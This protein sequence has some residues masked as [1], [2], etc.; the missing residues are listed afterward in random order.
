MISVIIPTC[1]RPPEFLKQAIDSVLSQSL[2]PSEIIVVDNGTRDAD[3]TAIPEG[4]TLYRL[5]PRVGPS[6]A[7]NFGAAMAKSSYLAFLDDDDWWD[8]NFI[9]EAWNILQ[10]EGVNCVYGRKDISR[11]GCVE[12]YKC[13][14]PETLNIPTLLRR[15]PG[16][17][18]QNLLITKKL[19][20]EVGGFDVKLR[21]SEDRSLALEILLIG[22]KIAIAPEAVLVMRNHDGVRARQAKIHQLFFVWKYRKK[23]GFGP[24]MIESFRVVKKSTISNSAYLIRKLYGKY[25]DN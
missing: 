13:L 8:K 19:F 14:S 1:D 21:T 17:G 2:A 9:N 7:R 15:N 24:M 5:P 16:T 22:N 23:L 25:N 10:S 20:W 3:P 6:R 12:P 11:N 18:G 4:V